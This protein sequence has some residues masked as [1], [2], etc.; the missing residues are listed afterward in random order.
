MSAQNTKIE[1][2][3]IN[4]NIS[5]FE[6]IPG[7]EKLLDSVMYHKYA[8][9]TVNSSTNSEIKFVNCSIIPEIKKIP[10]YNLSLQRIKFIERNTTNKINTKVTKY[11]KKYYPYGNLIFHPYVPK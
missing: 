10:V 4:N 1:L 3:P 6:V 11:K 9:E 8:E 2:A 5:S 7:F